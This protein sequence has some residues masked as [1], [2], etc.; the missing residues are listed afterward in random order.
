MGS[1]NV[2]AV[3]PPMKKIRE[4][5]LKF[6]YFFWS[7]NI[8]SRC[9]NGHLFNRIASEVRF[10]VIYI[11]RFNGPWMPLVF[12][13]LSV[14]MF[15]NKLELTIWYLYYQVPKGIK[16]NMLNIYISKTSPPNVDP[17]SNGSDC[18]PEWIAKSL[19]DAVNEVYILFI[20]HWLWKCESF[21]W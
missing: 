7:S 5:Q 17:C 4:L 16:N 12:A 13:F 3:G 19:V 2:Y 10:E 11:L 21:W 14:F 15:L 6:P 20:W 8:M 1:T 18:V 9:A